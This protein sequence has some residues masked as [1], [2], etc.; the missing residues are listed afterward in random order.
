MWGS[1]L[2][3]V[4]VLLVTGEIISSVWEYFN[5]FADVIVLPVWGRAMDPCSVTPSTLVFFLCY[6]DGT[7]PWAL[8]VSDVLDCCLHTRSFLLFYN[9]S[10]ITDSCSLWKSLRVSLQH[11]RHGY[12][13][14]QDHFKSLFVQVRDC[15]CDMWYRF[16]L[17][18]GSTAH[19]SSE[20]RDENKFQCVL[21]PDGAN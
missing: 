14:D 5:N 9:F 13:W 6:D 16:P 18:I 12:F 15:F 17:H 1:L 10:S 19:F 3:P 4:F 21:F 7:A 11:I 20:I 2:T 8:S